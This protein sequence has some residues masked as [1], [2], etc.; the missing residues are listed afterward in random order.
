WSSDVCSSDLVEP[1]DALG[2][3]PAIELVARRADA[4]LAARARLGL[5]A[6]HAPERLAEL[7]LD[8]HL[9][10]PVRA[11]VL[12]VERGGRRPAAVLVG[13]RGHLEGG[14]DRDREAA[15]GVLR[16]RRR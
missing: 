5:R 7:A 2:R 6:R 10:R 9:A 14:E 8:E 12:E 3:L 13:V 4:G 15:L 11:P 16:G 1:G